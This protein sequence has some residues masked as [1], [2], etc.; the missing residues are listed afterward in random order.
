MLNVASTGIYT[1]L[2]LIVNFKWNACKNERQLLWAQCRH[3]KIAQRIFKYSDIQYTSLTPDKMLNSLVYRT[4]F[5]VNIYGS[6]K[7]SKNSP[8]LFGPPCMSET[9]LEQKP[10]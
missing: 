1:K 6:F 4:L 10:D 5:Y 2:A 9:L 3:T 7:L 8:V